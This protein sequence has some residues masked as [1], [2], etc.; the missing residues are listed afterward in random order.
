MS[1]ALGA[2]MSRRSV[3]AVITVCV[4]GFAATSAFAASKTVTPDTVKTS[5]SGGCGTVPYVAPKDPQH[6]VAKLGKNYQQNYVGFR[7]NTIMKSAWANWKP[8]RKSGFNIQIVW[9]PK[10]NPLT[11]AAL[12]G[13]EA[14]LKASGK[15][16]TVQTQ[17][18]P[19]FT[20][21]AAQLQQLQT[22]IRRKPD[23]I[24][25]FPTSP[26][27]ST[28]LINAAGKAGIPVIMPTDSVSSKYVVNINS[29]IYLSQGGV[30]SFVLRSMGGKGSILQVN[31]IKGTSNDVTAE[32]TWRKLLSRCPNVKVA[33][34]VTSNFVDAL[35]KAGVQQFLATH[36]SGV[37]GVFTTGSIG[38]GIL[39]GFDATGRVAPPVGD[40]AALEGSLA[41]WHNHPSYK[42]AATLVTSTEFG[43][44]PAKVTLRMLAGDGVKINTLIDKP[45]LLTTRGQ[46]NGIW[47]SSYKEGSPAVV[48]PPKG[49]YFGTSYLNG[50][51]AR[52]AR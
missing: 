42:G 51:F 24:I 17:V 37:Q 16:K 8:K 41:Y 22:A 52:S 46:L 34:S 2:V 18:S 10:L 20:D 25:M 27:A 40:H 26:A 14:T 5:T 9:V 32:Y 11:N 48:P 36:P 3:T 35:A 38:N 7:S 28:P 29:N 15:V 30:G 4:A 33:G 49:A 19:G 39:S 31:G 44:V 47:K 43:V 12:A 1:R 45:F 50:F 13:I 21:V 23:A 6:L